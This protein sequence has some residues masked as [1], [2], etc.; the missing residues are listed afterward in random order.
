M[1]DAEVFVCALSSL[2]ITGSPFL[3][4]QKGDVQGPHSDLPN[5][6]DLLYY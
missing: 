4:T 6:V 3:N 5:H 1:P 2:M